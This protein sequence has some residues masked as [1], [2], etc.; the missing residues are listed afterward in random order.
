MKREID[1][2]KYKLKM[3]NEIIL[4]KS[5]LLCSLKFQV[6]EHLTIIF[7]I[8]SRIGYYCLG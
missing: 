4:M 2:E 1:T 7:L 3:L 8:L 6:N 5:K